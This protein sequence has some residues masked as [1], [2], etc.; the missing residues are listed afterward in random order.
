MVILHDAIRAIQNGGFVFL[1]K[2]N[3][4]FFLFKK[5]KKNGLKE[6]FS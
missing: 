2:K 1:F 4:T 6:S 5:T 3:K